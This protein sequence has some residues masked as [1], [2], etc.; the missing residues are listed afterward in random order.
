MVPAGRNSATSRDRIAS[1]AARSIGGAEDGLGA[2]AGRDMLDYPQWRATIGPAMSA[3]A[4]TS[5]VI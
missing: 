2:A 1:A 3:S 5:T 4:K